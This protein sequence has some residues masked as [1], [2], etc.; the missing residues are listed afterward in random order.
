MFSIV[1][2][3]IVLVVVSFFY[4]LVCIDDRNAGCLSTLKKIMTTHLPNA[5]RAGGKRI[6]GERAVGLV[7]R[8]INYICFEANPIVQ[9]IYFACA[10]G[11]FYIYVFYGFKHVPN[12]YLDSYHKVIGTII[13]LACY[14]CYFMAC[15]VSPG[16][17][18]K[19]TH[20][21]QMRRFKFDNILFNKK[22]NCKTC[23]LEKP[24]RSKHCSM[25][26]VCVEKFDHHCI[27]LN[28]CVGLHNYKW[29]LAFILLHFIITTYGFVVGIYIFKGIIDDKKLIGA[30]FRN[31]VT[32]EI[33][34]ADWHFIL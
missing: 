27:W 14:Y 13:M 10:F 5:I 3:G 18:L 29:F 25:C 26:N 11:G 23:E 7:D 34:T 12:E 15:W 31:N 4:L 16:H 30:Q 28:N 32:G 33:M 9:L 17:V 24:A 8:I 22:N 19:D 6:C 20:K 1:S 21:E 2:F